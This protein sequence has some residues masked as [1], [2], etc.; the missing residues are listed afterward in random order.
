[1]SEHAEAHD[2]GVALAR[3]RRPFV[4]DGVP[5]EVV[6]TS[7]MS[8]LHSMLAI[9]D[10]L[11]ARDWT[12]PG[13]PEAS[14]NHVLEGRLPNGREIVVEAGH[15]SWINFGI[16]VRS[17]GALV[18]ESHPGRRIAMPEG[19][20]RIAD[21]SEGYDA[22]ALSRDKVPLIVDVALGVL[23]YVVAKLTDLSTAALVGAAVGV[24]LFVV[25]RFVRVDLIGGLALF[26]VAMLLL[27]AGLAILFQ[28]DMAVKMRTSILGIVSAVLF[29]GDGLL[30]GSRLGKGLSR[31]LPYS[32]VDPGRLAVGMGVLGLLLAGLNYV[33]AKF[34]STDVWLFYSTFVDFL[35]VMV[36]M[37]LVLRFARG[38]MLPKNGA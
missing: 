25:Q 35:L 36:L 20:R 12:P 22:G 34:A 28:D 19:A 1:L 38:K 27:S 6:I 11:V 26:G 29:L 37:I 4:V 3:Y 21:A 32:D 17:G 24:G 10:E 9:G 7:R 13:G 16:A 14:R 5:C 23:F 8:G 33:V 15:I 30:G 31:Y 2:A 18:H